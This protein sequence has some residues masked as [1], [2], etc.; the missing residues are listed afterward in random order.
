[1]VYA[2]KAATFL[3]NLERAGVCWVDASS[4]VLARLD[5]E[6]IAERQVRCDNSTVWILRDGNTH[7]QDLHDLLKLCDPLLKLRIE[8]ANLL[9]GGD[10]SAYIG[11]GAKPS[12]QVSLRVTDRHSASKKPAIFPLFT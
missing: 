6:Q 1:M 12:H 4:N 8:I 3:I 9:F 5:S 11:A 10:L 7:R 2:R